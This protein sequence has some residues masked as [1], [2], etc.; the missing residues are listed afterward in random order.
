MMN[1][2]KRNKGNVLRKQFQPSRKFRASSSLSRRLL[3]AGYE[4]F[5]LRQHDIT[6][7]TSRKTASHTYLGFELLLCFFMLSDCLLLR[8]AL[9]RFPP[10]HCFVACVLVAFDKIRND[11]VSVSKPGGRVTKDPTQVL[12]TP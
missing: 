4:P 3:L 7:T 10:F 2:S 11:Q 9:A 5:S 8:L 12:P 1:S 6:N